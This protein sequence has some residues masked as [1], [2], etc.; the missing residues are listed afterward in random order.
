MTA[1]GLSLWA[2]LS[3]SKVTGDWGHGICGPWGCGP[4]VPALVACHFAWLVILLP[5]AWW[6]RFRLTHQQSF[7]LGLSHVVMAI[8]GLFAIALYE[9][10]TWWPE[11]SLWQRPYYWHR[12][13]FVVATT[14][15][16]PLVEIGIVGGMLLLKR[17]AVFLAPCS[18]SNSEPANDPPSQVLH[19]R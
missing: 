19:D 3:V 1:W 2:A 9:R 14:I 8:S 10:M 13:G 5:V 16:L 11:A 4:P 12:V 15:E 17:R 7:Y 6:S 18:D